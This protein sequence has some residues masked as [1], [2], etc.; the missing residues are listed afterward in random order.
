M[1]ADKFDFFFHFSYLVLSSMSMSL[2]FLYIHSSCVLWWLAF[3]K[4]PTEKLCSL[5]SF[6]TTQY[7]IW[8]C[9]RENSPFVI[10][11]FVGWI[12]LADVALHMAHSRTHIIFSCLCFQVC[13]IM[14]CWMNSPLM[15]KVISVE[16]IYVKWFYILARLHTHSILQLRR[17]ASIEPTVELT[18]MFVSWPCNKRIQYCL[19]YNHC[20]CFSCETKNHFHTVLC[21]TLFHVQLNESTTLLLE[22]VCVCVQENC[23][24]NCFG[25]PMMGPN[26]CRIQET[27]KHK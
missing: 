26:E 14:I 13:K 20:C 15:K 23:I 8:I 21:C 11:L 22:H 7:V 18:L 19:V 3:V 4:D 16:I 17:K 5:C 2:S 6:A 10:D 9:K 1:L 25:I 24:E 27:A 12:G